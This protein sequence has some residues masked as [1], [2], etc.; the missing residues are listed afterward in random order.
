MSEGLVAILIATVSLAGTGLAAWLS[1][2]AQQTGAKVQEKAALFEGYDEFVAHLRARVSE[3]EAG[4]EAAAE[5]FREAQVDCE[6]CRELLRDARE[7]YQALR[8]VLELLRRELGFPPGWDPFEHLE[9]ATGIRPYGRR[10]EDAPVP[11]PG[12]PGREH[13]TDPLE[14][15]QTDDEGDPN[16]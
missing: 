10:A 11:P 14:L 13:W 5:K 16:P 4:L 1:S 15:E 7:D 6:E 2:R 12:W 8:M 3:L 9:E